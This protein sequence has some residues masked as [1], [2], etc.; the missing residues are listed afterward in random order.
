MLGCMFSGKEIQ[1]LEYVLKKELEELL[2]DLED[3]RI[4]GLVKRSMEER[5][6]IIFRMYARFAIPKE[7][8]KYVRKRS[9]Q[10]HY[11]SGD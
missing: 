11:I 4:D 6:H 9:K 8:A 7:L 3:Q 1:E 10:G 2:L 5:Y